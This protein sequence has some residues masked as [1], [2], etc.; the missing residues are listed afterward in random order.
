MERAIPNFE[1]Y[2][3]TECG[4]VIGPRGGV[5]KPDTNSAGYLRV[6]LSKGGKVTRKF[7]HR[8][9]LETF[10]PA[11]K[12]GLVANHKDGDRLNNHINN[13]EW[14]SPSENVLHGWVRGRK[15]PHKY[16]EDTMGRLTHLFCLGLS[17]AE[18]AKRLR[19]DRSTVTRIFKELREGATT[20][21]KE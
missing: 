9:V 11:P 15:P 21:R 16:D 6:S 10:C 17:A 4:K 18:A 2:I 19:R 1:N 5:L 13:L 20:I 12:E 8:I 14:V 7:V 3:V